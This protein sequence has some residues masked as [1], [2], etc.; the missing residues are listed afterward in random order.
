LLAVGKAH[1][2]DAAAALPN[3]VAQANG[4]LDIDGEPVLLGPDLGPALS[5][6]LLFD[7]FSVVPRSLAARAV[8]RARASISTRSVR[9]SQHYQLKIAD[10]QRTPR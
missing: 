10:V 7:H 5:G 6:T 1:R 4:L 2:Q 3:Q 9:R 8:V